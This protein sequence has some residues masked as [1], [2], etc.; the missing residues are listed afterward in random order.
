MTS[1]SVNLFGKK[2]ALLFSIITI[3]KSSLISSTHTHIYLVFYLGLN[4][5]ELNDIKASLLKYD[6][7]EF[8]SVSIYFLYSTIYHTFII[9]IYHLFLFITEYFTF[10]RMYVC[11]LFYKYITSLDRSHVQIEHVR[12]ERRSFVT[13][14]NGAG[15]YVIGNI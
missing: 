11:Q 10:T 6:I 12:Y 1:D 8:Q 3:Q 5:L 2:K 4:I 9:N 15:F 7:K 13:M 14:I